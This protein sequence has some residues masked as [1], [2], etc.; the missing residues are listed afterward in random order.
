MFIVVP[1]RRP[2]VLDMRQGQEKFYFIWKRLSLG[3]VLLHGYFVLLR[4]RRHE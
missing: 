3:V 1:F 4:L 2:G